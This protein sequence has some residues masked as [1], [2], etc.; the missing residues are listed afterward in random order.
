MILMLLGFLFSVSFFGVATV[1]SFI[2]FEH[3]KG[4]GVALHN[5]KVEEIENLLDDVLSANG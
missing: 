1:R 2:D 3:A 5:E 4:L